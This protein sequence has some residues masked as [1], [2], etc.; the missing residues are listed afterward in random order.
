MRRR[1]T[2]ACVLLVVAAALFEVTRAQL[3]RAGDDALRGTI[4]FAPGPLV[5]RTNSDRVSERQQLLEQLK[6]QVE[7]MSDEEVTQ[8]LGATAA[9]NRARQASRK[10]GE[11]AATLREFAKEFDGTPAAELAK[12]MV[13][14]HQLGLRGNDAPFYGSPADVRPRPVLD[15]PVPTRSSN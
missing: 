12:R 6:T 9:E 3:A 15:Q 4:E 1:L 2:V 8:A 14:L 7:L 11:T 10:L 5:N 13:E